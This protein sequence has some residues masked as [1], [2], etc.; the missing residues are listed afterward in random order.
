[1]NQVSAADNHTIQASASHWRLLHNKKPLAE[2]SSRGFRYGGR[3]GSSRRLP[4][5]GNLQAKQILQVVLGWQ[6]T[7]ESW[8]LGLILAPDI[9]SQRGSRWCEL[10]HWPD[11]DISVFQDLAQTTGQ[12]LA[13]ALDVPFYT[14]PPQ[15][16]DDAPPPRD[17]PQLPLNFSD[18]QMDAVAGDKYSFVI[19][20]TRS[21]TFRKLRRIAWYAFWMLVYLILSLATLVSDIALPNTGTLLPNPKLL[22]YMGLGIVV[23]LI[24]VMVYH[25]L[26]M[27][28]KPDKI[29]IDGTRAAV[30]AWTGSKMRWVVPLAEIQSIYV[31]EM[32]KK[33]EQA[34]MTKYAELNLH[35]GGGDFHFV[36]AQEMPEENKHT[37]QPELMIPRSEDIRDM[38][39][40]IYYTDLQA[41]ALYISEALGGLPTWYDLRA[42]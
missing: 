13:Q 16:V 25:F 4:E 36:L 3:F 14:I 40:E 11:P 9:A 6:Q 27:F 2:G 37:P 35:L 17:L 32:V 39:R 38:N 31:S 15:A 7:D 18:W 20:R 8:H 10:V 21:W 28:R 24:G 19:K 41:A 12:G 26:D 1:M 23:M 29:F 5:D 22:P 33:N 34:P 42:E 30:S